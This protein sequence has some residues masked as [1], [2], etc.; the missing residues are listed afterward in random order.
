MMIMVVIM[1]SNQ[2]YFKDLRLNRVIFD[3]L[4]SSPSD[5][6]IMISNLP[7]TQYDHEDIIQLINGFVNKPLY[8]VFK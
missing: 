6:T 5:Y 3:K 7:K 8:E 2:I 4:L 1:I